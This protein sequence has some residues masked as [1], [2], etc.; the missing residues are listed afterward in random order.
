MADLLAKARASR[1]KAV[2]TLVENR[3]KG[4]TMMTADG[5]LF[6]KLK[7]RVSLPVFKSSRGRS[8]TKPGFKSCRS[9]QN[10]APDSQLANS[11]LNQAGLS[12]YLH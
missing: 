2:E 10:G 3:A 11:L 5:R 8:A 7:K 4:E 9:L 6:T 12:R 1:K